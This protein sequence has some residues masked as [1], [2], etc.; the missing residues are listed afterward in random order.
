MVKHIMSDGTRVKKIDGYVVPLNDST[1]R[2]Y[3][4]LI[5]FN[6]EEGDQK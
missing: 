1:K 4:I 3:Q 5:E 6:E 2:A